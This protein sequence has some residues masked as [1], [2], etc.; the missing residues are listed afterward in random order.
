MHQAVELA[1]KNQQPGVGRFK[2]CLIAS[3]RHQLP[4]C[5]ARRDRSANACIDPG[6]QR[7]FTPG[8]LMAGQPQQGVFDGAWCAAKQCQPQ[9][10]K[11]VAGPQ[12]TLKRA[13]IFKTGVDQHATR[14]ILRKPLSPFSRHHGTERHGQQVVRRFDALAGEFTAAKIHHTAD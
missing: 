1:A 13:E 4:E 7:A 2:A 5:I 10:R 8:N 3:R 12:P 9:Q 11:V 6:S 14:N